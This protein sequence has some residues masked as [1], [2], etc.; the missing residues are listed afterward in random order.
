MSKLISG[1][2]TIDNQDDIVV[3]LIG[4][5]VNKFWLLPFALPILAKMKTMLAELSKEP[6]SGLLGYQPL[7]LGG[8]VQYW[9]SAEQLLRYAEDSKRVHKPTARRFFQKLFK[10]ES[11]G[12]WHETF[13]VRAGN[14][15]ALYVNM[16]AWGMSSILSVHPV[17]GERATAERRLWG[18]P[19]LSERRGRAA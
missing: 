19:E 8:T 16:P 3:M 1:R 10:N 14:Y 17:E 13:V 5:R 2:N 9:R 12:I 15:E 4:A 11:V 6:D 18:V 7:G